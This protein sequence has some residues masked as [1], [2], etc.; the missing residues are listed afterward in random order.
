ME[1]SL[2]TGMKSVLM[3]AGACAKRLLTDRRGAAALEFAFIAPVLLSL[4]FV[5]MEVSQGIETNKKV[6]RIGSMVADLVTQQQGEISRADLDA[7]M[8]IGGAII[9]PYNRTQPGI[10]VTAI[11]ITDEENPKARVAWSRKM[12]N[13]AFSQD[14]PRNSETTVPETLTIRNTFLIRVASG[15]DY[16]PVIT[17]AADKKAS[18]GLAAS[19][20]NIAM[21]ETYHLRP[22]M[23]TEITCPDC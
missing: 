20:D 12:V 23:S 1:K 7:I 21:R 17:W 18:M 22:R 13:G 19:F 10:V 6:S 2:G 8:R 16:R 4:Y 11:K 9:Q 5:T 3:R 15:L 14:A